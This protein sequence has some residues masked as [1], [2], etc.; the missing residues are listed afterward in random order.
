MNKPKHRVGWTEYSLLINELVKQMNNDDFEPELIITIARG[1]LPGAVQLSH[2]F[3]APMTIAEV[4]KY[5]ENDEAGE[6]EIES[7]PELPDL[8]TS[9][10]IFDDI[11]DTGETM[12]T[13]TMFAEWSPRVEVKTAT[14]HVKPE[15][16]FVPDYWVT[17]TDKW[18]VYPWEETL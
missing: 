17:R 11:S 1:G 13:I 5:D 9:A 2:Q 14:M 18:V 16:S 8:D 15:T 12:R 6:L 3:E 10:L 4:S 7:L